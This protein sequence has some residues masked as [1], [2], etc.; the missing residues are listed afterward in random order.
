MI[1]RVPTGSS[2]SDTSGGIG[3]ANVNDL[4]HLTRDQ[5]VSRLRPGERILDVG[6]GSG[7]IARLMHARG[8]AVVGIELSPEKAAKARAFCDEVL[9]GNIE[10]M[11]L[12]FEPG[13]FDVIVL[14]NILEHLNNPVA[15]LRRLAPLLRPT[16]RAFVDLPNVA[17]W[18]VRLRLLRGRWD[19]EDA[20]I[21]D[22]THLRFYTRKTAREMLEQT[23]FEILEQ[24]II[25]DVPLLR[26]KQRW[27]QLNYH[28]ARLR[29]DL[30][31]T[32]MLFVVHPR[33]MT[34]SR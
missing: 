7:E 23:G 22:R 19:Y 4:P 6:C 33:K 18:G 9:V 29:P 20:G 12:A 28:V 34:A 2:L 1:G 11:P 21:L 8:C 31:S 5:I 3:E 32:E 14:S 17:H 25:P 10:A 26:Y 30:F 15:T 27:A 13:S 16:G 24:D